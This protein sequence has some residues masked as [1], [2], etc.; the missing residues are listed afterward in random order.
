MFPFPNL[1]NYQYD[2]SNLNHPIGQDLTSPLTIQKV[3]WEDKSWGKVLKVTFAENIKFGNGVLNNLHFLRFAENSENKCSDFENGEAFFYFMS[4]LNQSVQI[5]IRSTRLDEQKLIYWVLSDEIIEEIKSEKNKWD[6]LGYIEEKD[7]IWENKEKVEKKNWTDIHPDFAKDSG[8]IITATKQKLT[9]QQWWE[10]KG[11]TVEEIKQLVDTGLH[12]NE[13]H[14]GRWLKDKKQFNS[15][16]TL[17]ANELRTEY[18]KLWKDIH[19]DFGEKNWNDK[20]YQ[21]IWEEKGLTYQ[22]VQGWIKAGFE[23]KD[24]EKVIEWKNHNFTPQEAKS[25][26]DIGLDEKQHSEFATYLRK[27]NYTPEAAF[28][29]KKSYAQY[30]L[31]RNYPQNQRNTISDLHIGKRFLISSLDLSDFV[32]LKKLDCSHNNLTQVKLPKGEKLKELNLSNN[33]LNQDLSFV[34]K[35][36]NLEKLYIGNNKFTGSLETLKN[37]TKLEK[38]DIRDTDIDSGLE[39]LSNSIKDFWCSADERKDAKCQGIYKSFAFASKQGKAETDGHGKVRNFSW[40]LQE[41]KKKIKQWKK[42]NFSSEEINRWINV[43]LTVSESDFANYL[44]KRGYQ[45]NTP[46]IR[47]ITKKESWQDIHENF[48]YWWRKKWEEK[49]FDCEQAKKWITLLGTGFKVSDHEY[50]TWLRDTKQIDVESMLDGDL[51]QKLREEYGEQ[52]LGIK[53]IKQIERFKYNALTPEQKSLI[54]QLISSEELKE[55]YQKYGLCKKCQQPK[56]D[57]AWCQFC[58]S[59]HFAW[60]FADWTSGNKVIDEFIQ[61]QQIR[62]TNHDD[63]LEWMPYN[64]FINVEY[65]AQ[66]G[67]GKVYKAKWEGGYI[68]NWNDK[69]NKWQRYEDDSKGDVVL[70]SLHNSQDI[71]TD[72]LQE[73]AYHHRLIDDNGWVVKCYG[74]SQNPK[75]KNYLMV[76]R[77]IGDNMRRYLQNNYNKLSFSGKMNQLKDIANGLNSIHRQRLVHRDFHA[78]NILN[79]TNSYSSKFHIADLGLCRPANETDEEKIYGVLPYVAP[80]VL[81]REPYTQASDIYSWGIIACEMFSGLPPYHDIA[82]DFRLALKICEGLRPNLNEVK[83]P[84]LLKDLTSKCLD[85]EPSNRPTAEE[86]S[87][88][89]ESWD[90]NVNNS[91]RDIEFYRQYKEIIDAGEFE[92][93]LSSITNKLVYKTHSQAIYTSRLLNFKNLPK[94]Q[95]N[96]SQEWQTSTLLELRINGIKEELKLFKKSREESAE[97]IENFIQNKK[98]VIKEEDNESKNEARKLRKELEEKGFSTEDM[99]EIVRYCEELVNLEQ[100][101]ETNDQVLT[102]QAKRQLS[103]NTQN[104]ITQEKNKLFR[105]IEEDNKSEAINL[106]CKHNSAEPTEIDKLEQFASTGIT[107][108]LNQLNILDWQNIHSSFTSQLIQ[109]W[110]Q[111][112]FTYEQTR[113]WINIHS[114]NDQG[115]AIQE[116]E[117]YA[118][119]RDI[120]QLTPEWVLNYSN[121]DTLKREYQQ[122]QFQAQIIQKTH[123][124]N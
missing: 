81:K 62:A 5:P 52:W 46:D 61:K 121:I 75:T 59:Q 32:N 1:P 44:R 78:G 58:N 95:T 55:K 33:N 90:I 70:K 37:L 83:A 80:E 30:W 47:E 54:N 24:Y 124:N 35:L 92:K 117:F 76:M 79:N 122:S 22:D 64:R 110:I 115:Q 86:L 106:I 3:E 96:F 48:R 26:R 10:N 21:Q 56:S 41:I 120:K 94:L 12:P 20:T 57:R 84:Q 111:H 89:L 103:L 28:Q 49:G 123:T 4:K 71:T 108:E 43:G 50:C 51:E 36:V 91:I 53:T 119:L 15:S 118:W 99:S 42:L 97:L 93:N 2:F 87:Q 68:K 105:I 67:F 8:W 16:L 19:E 69:N 88:I 45:P 23:P 17:N 63:L 13:P 73:V 14:F 114:P 9:W 34:S 72:F 98:K 116:P 85:A 113:D 77:Y 102:N 40:K 6:K 31:D 29:E 11:F 104:T 65:L 18:N 66:G 101:K 112:N 27:N 38:L 74:I 82:H 25:W 100:Q 39:C 109:S 60:G 107:K 7:L